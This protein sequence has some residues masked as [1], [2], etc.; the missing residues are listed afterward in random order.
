MS[1][2]R[3]TTTVPRRSYLATRTYNND[4]FQYLTSN[5]NF[6]TIGGLS[7]VPTANSANCLQ[8]NLLV[9]TGARLYP[10][11][12]PG[13]STMM[14]GVMDYNALSNGTTVKGYIDPNS[15]AFAIQNTDRTYMIN[16]PGSNPYAVDDNGASWP[17]DQS[18]PVF[19]RG[20]VKADGNAFIRGSISTLS[21]AS[22]AGNT[23]INGNLNVTGGQV[24]ASAIFNSTFG[25]GGSGNFTVDPTIG[26]VFVLT[27]LSGSS[28]NLNITPST[29]LAGAQLFF[30]LSNTSGANR[31]FDFNSNFFSAAAGINTVPTGQMTTA[32]FFSDGVRFYQTGGISNVTP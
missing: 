17:N 8:G 4:I 2:S 31:T 32:S 11:T 28:S 25:T 20:N 6:Q 27:L 30:V 18:A 26:Q 14:V 21:N 16:N 3:T 22:I 29:M 19:T 1:V 13:V 5:I 24:R 10:G 23:V 15:F 7:A 12:H 9:E